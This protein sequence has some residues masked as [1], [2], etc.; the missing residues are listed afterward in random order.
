[1][2]SSAFG[3]VATCP[4]FEQQIL[5]DVCGRRLVVPTVRARRKA[6]E[7]F[8]GVAGR[9]LKHRLGV[10][11]ELDRL[12]VTTGVESRTRQLDQRCRDLRMIGGQHRA[13]DRER[14]RD[15]A[16]C[17]GFVAELVQ[18]LA[19]VEMRQR[20]ASVLLAELRLRISRAAVDRSASAG[21]RASRARRDT[22]WRTRAPGIDTER[23]SGSQRFAVSPSARSAHRA[24]ERF[25]RSVS[26]EA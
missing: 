2:Y 1:M 26:T 13:I 19:E 17:F 7:R 12:G 5:R 8:D 25:A 14:L 11:R 21:G 10:R 4:C 18:H 24:P 23:F 3:I 6:C 9:E 22:E 16:R 15:L 20:G